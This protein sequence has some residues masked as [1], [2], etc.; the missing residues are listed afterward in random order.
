NLSLTTSQ[1]PTVYLPVEIAAASVSFNVPSANISVPG[2]L[3]YASPTQINVQIPWELQGQSSASVKVTING[4]S[5]DPFTIPIA[6]YGPGFFEFADP[7]TGQTLVAALDPFVL[8]TTSHPAK[9]GTNISLYAN[10]LGPVTNQPASG[11]IAPAQQP[12]AENRIKPVVTIGGRDA[13]VTFSG[14]APFYVG[15]YQINVV[16]P[17]D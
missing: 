2:H 14:L 17:P 10:G 1:Y 3:W 15:L 7:A 16:V 13:Q 9:R 11:D 8:I 5:S 6:D 12:F 4:I